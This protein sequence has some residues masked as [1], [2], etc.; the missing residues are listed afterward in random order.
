MK[1]CFNFSW[2]KNVFFLF[3]AATGFINSPYSNSISYEQ[4]ASGFALYIF[5]LTT[6]QVYRLNHNVHLKLLPK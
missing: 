4:F 3:A 2:L 5:D 1:K 6:T